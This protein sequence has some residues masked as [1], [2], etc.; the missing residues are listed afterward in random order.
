MLCD[1]KSTAESAWR[2]PGGNAGYLGYKKRKAV[3]REGRGKFESP[4]SDMRVASDLV[5]E[6]ELETKQRKVWGKC[7]LRHKTD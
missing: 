6:G 5:L 2:V 3:T 1:L 4:I 7:K